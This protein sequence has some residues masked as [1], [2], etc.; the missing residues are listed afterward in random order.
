MITLKTR[1]YDGIYR[2]DREHYEN[3]DET[4]PNDNAHLA[5][6]LDMRDWRR[7]DTRGTYGGIG[8][9]H[10]WVEVDDEEIVTAEDERET[11]FDDDGE[12]T[13]DEQ[14]NVLELYGDVWDGNNHI[15][16]VPRR[17]MRYVDNPSVPLGE[18]GLLVVDQ[19][20]DPTDVVGED[21]WTLL[22]SR[23]CGHE[24]WELADDREA[25]EAALDGAEIEYEIVEYEGWEGEYLLVREADADA[26]RAALA[27]YDP[28]EEED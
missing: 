24:K 17:A 22:D 19:T 16:F 20:G 3:S 9:G 18:H 11:V 12:L 27:A 13:D 14:A 26:A 4:W 10:T 23:E 1:L 2:S 21:G 7:I 5:L 28:D 15:E 25:V 8:A 6:A